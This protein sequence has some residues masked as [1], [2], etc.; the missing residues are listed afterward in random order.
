MIEQWQPSVSIKETIDL[1]LL[2]QFIGH[3]QRILEEDCD[4]TALVS[5]DAQQRAKP[6]LTLS[7]AQWG[8]TLAQLPVESLPALA[9][10]YTLA[11]MQFSGWQC[12]A[13]NPAIWIFRWLKQQAPLDKALITAL[14]KLTDN[15][16]I[17]YG[18]VF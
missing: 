2:Q 5:A 4:L 6:W 13:K 7:E 3:G 17:P 12:G 8:S 16:Y 1:T 15:R 9:A 18:S 14:K 11:E 10:F